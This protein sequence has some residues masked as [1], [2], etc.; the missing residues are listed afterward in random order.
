[1]SQLTPGQGPAPRRQRP[2]SVVIRE[3]SEQGGDLASLMDPATKSLADALR[4]TYRIL[5]FAMG[6]LVIV[7]CFSGVQTVQSNEKGVRLFVGKID[8]D[9]LQPGLQITLPAPFGELVTVPSGVETLK[10]DSEFWPNVAEA[11][12]KKS[13]AELKN[14]P[15]GKLDPA[16]DGSIITADGNLAHG[17]FTV[18][19]R[20]ERVGEYLR[21]I[22]SAD[23]AKRLVK[24]AV[25]RGVVHAAST[26]SIDEFLKD[27]ADP[28]RRVESF[29]A[30]AGIAREVAQDTLNR[31]QCGI[32]LSELTIQDRTPPIDTIKD[33]EK[34]QTEQ[35]RANEQIQLAEQERIKTLSSA[36]GQAA[37]PLLK[38]IDRFDGLLSSGKKVEGEAMLAKIDTVMDGGEVE[39][40]DQKLVASIG[41]KVAKTL[42]S[43]R[44]YRS[45]VVS[46]SQADANL[47][48]V[49]LDSYR[50]NPSVLL[51]GEWTDAFRAF[52]KRENVELVLLPPGSR[53]P[54][55]MLN[56][57][58]T[59]NR[60]R[61]LAATRAE[62]D[63][64]AKQQTK[65]FENK[66]FQS[67]KKAERF[68]E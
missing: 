9:D 28:G 31:M 33:F 19:F 43:A 37:E 58:P 65:E 13:P 21:T 11:D 14:S 7:F 39:L 68:S 62:A 61:T 2:A 12:K 41:G 55:I 49:K 60:L 30:I 42:S 16:T 17:R 4:I 67:E 34:V 1:M 18:T 6:A 51:T 8:T 52:L 57:D 44:E 10:V 59:L 48:T 27:Q 40:D 35:S 66:K 29:R 24:A 32:T 63:E 54:Q 53:T 15:R 47:F 46:R 26:V 50:K 22:A 45:S 36:A 20:R 64:K 23:D 5:Q 38:L 56:T 3:Q 25:Q